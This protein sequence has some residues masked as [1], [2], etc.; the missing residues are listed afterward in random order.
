M[1]KASYNRLDIVRFCDDFVKVLGLDWVVMFSQGHLHDSTVVVCLKML[2]ALLSNASILA[3]FRDASHNGG[4]LSN[5]QMV[6]EH[7][8]NQAVGKEISFTI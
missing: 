5:A 8:Q 7:R 1:F 2:V 3:K 4:W 6:I